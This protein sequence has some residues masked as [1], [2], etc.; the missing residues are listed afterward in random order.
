MA[1][2]RVAAVAAGAALLDAAIMAT[3]TLIVLEADR[4]PER[5]DL[6][7]ELNR[8]RRAALAVGRALDAVAG[9]MRRANAHEKA[10][11]AAHALHVIET[12]GVATLA[13]ELLSVP[14]PGCE[15]QE[16]DPALWDVRA[17][18]LEAQRLIEN[19]TGGAA[20][21]AS[22]AGPLRVL[23]QHEG[24]TVDLV[25]FLGSLEEAGATLRDVGRSALRVTAA[26]EA[27]DAMA[28]R[29]VGTPVLLADL[30]PELK[31]DPVE[32][33]EL[34]HRLNVR[35]GD[36]FVDEQ[37]AVLYKKSTSR[38]ARVATYL[39]PVAWTLL[40]G[41]V[42]LLPFWLDLTEGLWN[43][44]ADALRAYA[45]VLAGVAM[46]LVVTA[47][48]ERQGNSGAPLPLGNPLDWLH[49]RWAGVAWTFVSAVIVVFGMGLNGF[50]RIEATE[51]VYLYL[52]A[53]YSVDSIA[54]L[55]LTRFDALAQKGVRTLDEKIGPGLTVKPA[56]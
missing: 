36:L 41:C 35:C 2:V 27:R 9:A 44:P 29:S 52:F 37:R 40:G 18:L 54:G 56:S 5:P 39:A 23:A 50:A 33:K 48:K 22:G 53:G 14:W 26:A 7:A 20:T 12:T 3:E 31:D 46:H 55:F 11:A 21:Q 38:G 47:Q 32:Q 4:R 6:W 16:H 34:A 30:F 10:S 42:V 13:E 45:L 51:V 17:S 8:I 49:T 25:P 43:E 19:L 1:D 28:G 24:D 15:D